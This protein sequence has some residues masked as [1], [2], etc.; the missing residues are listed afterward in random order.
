M[1]AIDAGVFRV[2]VFAAAMAIVRRM[3]SSLPGA[4]PSF[5]VLEDRPGGVLT[6]NKP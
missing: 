5:Q 3:V 1:V 4:A 2:P 6:V